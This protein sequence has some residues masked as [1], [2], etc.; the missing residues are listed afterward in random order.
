M[1][2]TL[3]KNQLYT[4]ADYLT[5]MDDMRRELIDGV[6]SFIAK[7]SPAPIDVHAD[8]SVNIVVSLK[9]YIKKSKGNCKVRFAP[10]D[11]RFPNNGE[12]DDKKIY[13]VVQP[14]IC[15]ICDPSKIDRRGCIGAPDFIAEI[16][17]PSSVSYDTRVKYELYQRHGVKEYW[18]VYPEG[19]TVEVNVLQEDGKYAPPVLFIEQG[20]IPVATLPGL[21]IPISDIFEPLP[22]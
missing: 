1:E 11:V 16:I 17:S 6:I 3:D 22:N 21:T 5:W 10:Y 4:F 2:L 14:D 9:N 15:I 18:M 7:M 12:T 13:T 19:N 8:C 20:D